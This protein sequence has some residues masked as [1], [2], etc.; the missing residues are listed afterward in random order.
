LR[1]LRIDARQVGTL[2]RVV[3]HR[4]IREHP[5][6]LRLLDAQKLQHRQRLAGA[7]GLQ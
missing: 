6:I 3:K 2:E 1:H 5:A 4:A 7:P